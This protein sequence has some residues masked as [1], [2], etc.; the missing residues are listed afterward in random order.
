MNIVTKTTTPTKS[1][2]TLLFIVFFSLLGVGYASAAN[3]DKPYVVKKYNAANNYFDLVF[4]YND[5]YNSVSNGEVIFI[6][7]DNPIWINE[8]DKIN[9]VT[10]HNSFTSYTPTSCANWFQGVAKFNGLS[11]L[12][13]SECKSMEGMFMNCT[14]NYITG[15][16][17]LK[18][19]AVTTM[20]DMFKGCS[21]LIALYF[22]NFNTEKVKDMSGMFSGCTNLSSIDADKLNSAIVT[23]MSSMFEGCNNFSPFDILDLLDNPNFT[24]QEVTNMS[25]MF[26]DCATTSTFNKTL[27]FKYFTTDKVTNFS[28]MFEGCLLVDILD[29]H[30]FSSAS[31]QNMSNMFKNC[32][33][34]KTIYVLSDW[35][36]EQLSE[37]Q[38]IDMYAGCNKLPTDN[39]LNKYGEIYVTLDD[40]TLTFHYDLNKLNYST[41]YAPIDATS[42]PNDPKPE[43]LSINPS[44]TKVEFLEEFKDA[45]PTHCAYW[46]QGCSQL[47]EI[48][49]MN[50]LNVSNVNDLSY[51]FEN[52][53]NLKVIDIRSFKTDQVFFMYRMFS[54]CGNLNTILISDK[55]STE[56]LFKHL[57]D[58]PIDSEKHSA[59]QGMFYN[60]TLLIGDDGTCADTLCVKTENR[61][62]NKK[63]QYQYAHA[64]K[65]GYMT[66]DYFKVFN[67]STQSEEWNPDYLKMTGNKKWEKYD[68]IIVDYENGTITLPTITPPP[69]YWHGDKLY[70]WATIDNNNQPDTIKIEDES[71]TINLN[72]IGLTN[73]HYE[74]TP[75]FL[76]PY[77]EFEA[78]TGTLTFK[79]DT[80]ISHKKVE[81]DK[82]KH[83]IFDV[84]YYN[85]SGAVGNPGWVAFR[86]NEITTVTFDK[87]FKEYQLE[88]FVSSGDGTHYCGCE[89]WF[90]N[91]E[92]LTTIT[93]VENFN[94]SKVTTMN[95]MFYGCTS[96]ATIPFKFKADNI[97]YLTDM[98]ANSGLTKIE[99]DE[100]F[101]TKNVYS[102]NGM[103][104][105]CKNLETI[106]G[107]EYFDTKS[108]FSFQ[109]MFLGCESLTN[110]DLNFDTQ[111]ATDMSRMFRDCKNLTSIS[112]GEKFVTSKVKDMSQMFAECTSL[113]TLDLSNFDTQNVERCYQ[114]FAAEEPMFGITGI[115]EM[116]LTTILVGDGWNLKEDVD[117]DAM[118]IGCHNLMGGS[119]IKSQSNQIKPNNSDEMTNP[120]IG[121]QYANA[122]TG[123]LTK[124]PYTIEY[125]DAET[126]ELL[127][128][129]ITANLPSEI[130]GETI[131]I[132]PP[133]RKGYV[134]KGWTDGLNG[135]TGLSATD[136]TDPEKDIEIEPT[137]KYNHVYVA[138]W[139]KLTIDV[140]L[141]SSDQLYYPIDSAAF[142]NNNESGLTLNFKAN[143]NSPLPAHYTLSFSSS[144]IPEQPHG[145]VNPDVNGEFTVLVNIPDYTLSDDYIGKIVFAD[146]DEVS[147]SDPIEF[148]LTTNIPHKDVILY[149]Y[150]NVIFVSNQSGRYNDASY[151]WFK[152]GNPVG[153]KRQYFTE[154]VISGSYGARINIAGQKPIYTC[155][156]VDNTVKVASSVV[157]VFPNPALAG[158]EF[159]VEIMNYTPGVEYKILVFSN[160]GA[161]VRSIATTEATTTL[162]LPRGI[163]NI[164]LTA[165]GNKCGAFKIIVEE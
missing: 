107:L 96:L 11:Y 53:S 66:K 86:K 121:S 80:K 15:I 65:G 122:K 51:M 155:A 156:L 81:E 72:E 46:F 32:S 120:I 21:N 97:I 44:V 130:K 144:E 22:D 124:L 41:T 8:G 37:D 113:D 5:E 114:M 3:E 33:N 18:T 42:D 12:N 88:E 147:F 63:Y 110:L 145:S 40:N 159:T 71:K 154:P 136:P 79:Y 52:C 123:Y 89:G 64:N 127:S 49:G 153:E 55:W 30:T 26:K 50:Y 34:L 150:S 149:L 7:D 14:A 116:K 137:A 78:T 140:N 74:F 59:S 67:Y 85:G 99:F 1:I 90:K 139:E 62:R 119:G 95:E 93:G 10:I 118:F 57:R 157:K 128:E 83:L 163:Y 134:F 164:A 31:A 35:D 161:Q 75:V 82:N 143:L 142:C 58:N 125:K 146:D 17:E 131:T 20:K 100:S 13:T 56:G 36:P 162:S 2:F 43:W 132:K 105:N 92:N 98:F 69:F 135:N 77:A 91:C 47:T 25:N 61:V 29:I 45:R 151:Q 158:K 4:Y 138:H 27:E 104:Y 152:D 148:T 48:V 101:D 115:P 28:G 23:D 133:S 70:G 39:P 73:G 87:S 160:N 94:Y 102:M 16:E 76:H 6:I 9:S 129:A 54:G 108:C 84:I 111:S 103:F 24:T 112:F 141:Q 165:N 117:G 68:N 60:D 38:R 126:D 109:S 19:D 106:I